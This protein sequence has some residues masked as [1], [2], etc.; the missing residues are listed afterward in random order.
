MARPSDA[1]SSSTHYRG[2]AQAEETDGRLF[3]EFHFP[4]SRAA[5]AEGNTDMTRTVGV[6][7]VSWE[8]TVCLQGS[9]N[10]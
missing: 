3:P 4:N 6:G 7:L 8:I 2:Q 5:K 10:L 9:G 1:C